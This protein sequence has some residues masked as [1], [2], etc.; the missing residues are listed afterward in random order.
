MPAVGQG[1]LQA[2]GILGKVKTNQ[3]LVQLGE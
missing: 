1:Q 2:V 3:I